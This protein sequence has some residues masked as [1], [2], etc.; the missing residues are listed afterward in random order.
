[1]SME[2]MRWSICILIFVVG[3]IGV[4]KRL[5]P[6]IDSVHGRTSDVVTIPVSFEWH[7]A[8]ERA[9]LLLA[10]SSST[11]SND[12]PEATRV[13]E[14]ETTPVQKTQEVVSPGVAPGG[15]TAEVNYGSWAVRPGDSLWK[16][17]GIVLGDSTRLNELVTLNPGINPEKLKEGQ[18]LRVPRSGQQEISSVQ[19]S[20]QKDAALVHKVQKGETLIS[21]ARQHYGTPNWGRIQSA[22]TNL[23]AN[24]DQ[25]RVGMVL[26][27]PALDGGGQGRNR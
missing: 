6:E 17:A 10:E 20:V 27:I 12:L 15:N 26:T 5:S 16:I 19:K 11:F 1:M 8:D 22:N 4:T 25:L 14:S 21:I 18:V 3:V 7:S 23:I 2:K 24:P 13:T 9:R